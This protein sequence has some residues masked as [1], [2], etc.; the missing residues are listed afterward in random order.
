VFQPGSIRNS[1]LGGQSASGSQSG[2]ERFIRLKKEIHKQLV[3]R[4]HLPSIGTVDD[5]EL[6]RELRRGI[7]Q[8]CVD[9]AELMS[10][11]ERDRLINDIID[12]VLG[13][14]PID[15]LL[16]DPTITD[17]LINGPRTVY[18]ERRGR[19]ERTNVVFHDEQHVL[20]IVQRIA[21]R[22]GRRL[23]ESSPMVDARLPDGSRVNAVIRPLALD[24]AL[25]S[26]RRFSTRPLLASDLIARKSVTSD[27]IEFLAACV[28][29]R[30][31]ILISGGT[32][33]G[34]T[35]F[36]NM[37]SGYISDDE[38]IATIEDAAELQLQ[39][40]HVARMETRPPNLEGKGEVTTKDLVR[41]ALRM[42]PDRI[43]IGECRGA[44][45][46]DMLQA[47]TT[48]HD[49][50]LTTIH[51]NNT[52]EAISR[53]EMLIGMAGYDLPIW[54]IHRQIATAIDIVVQC[55]RL[56]GGARKVI[57]VSEVTGAEGEVIN[58]H[59]IFV[60]EQTG[61]DDNKV[62]QGIFRATGIRPHCLEKLSSNGQQI[63]PG[64][65]ERRILETDRLDSL[66]HTSVR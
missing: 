55:A 30:M 38:R 19:L 57:Q 56:S 2:D 41:N 40:P 14:G 44:E 61:V 46:F 45:A 37:L 29:S 12:E 63:A 32:G 16:R 5:Y 42:R 18:V 24:G 36:L 51:A 54:F 39:Q 52:R 6:R 23:D 53:L 43:L 21:S 10:Q 65:F 15:P 35:T 7:E 64:L 22:V 60:F 27:I 13:L 50:G 26:I 8:L 20:E 49:G 3:T 11:E 4:L 47:M 59:D 25:V 66:V 17:I 34:K 62:A 28:R 58:M 9:R 48:G 31:N 1:G 33:S